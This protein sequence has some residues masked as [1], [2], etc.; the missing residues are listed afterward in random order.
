[1]QEFKKH[2]GI[3]HYLE[4]EGGRTMEFFNN[5]SMQLL[6]RAL[7][8]STLRQ[9]VLT[10]NIA[11]AETP[12]YKRMDVRFEAEL[13]K[14]IH[15][16][17]SRFIGYRTDAKHLEIGASRLSNIK[18]RIVQEGNY[19]MNNNKNN[20]DLDHEMAEIAKN[21]IRYQVLVQQSSF[22]GYR[23]AIEGGNG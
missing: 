5:R 23:I 21:G 2:C 18:P 12:G 17:D 9:N 22:S 13:Q 1:V 3:N 6:E 8:V 19:V 15:R 10:N 20:V 16:S 7:N 14:A 4:V 11:N